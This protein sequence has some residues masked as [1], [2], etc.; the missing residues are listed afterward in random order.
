MCIS[1][2]FGPKR[3]SDDDHEQQ[4]KQPEKKTGRMT[5]GQIFI[6]LRIDP[7][8]FFHVFMK[9]K[10]IL[11]LHNIRSRRMLELSEAGSC[12]TWGKVFT[13]LHHTCPAPPHL[14]S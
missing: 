11:S 10:V 5:K 3:Y 9:I 8:H 7:D 4:V 1:S 12:P 2:L 6:L 13:D 14:P